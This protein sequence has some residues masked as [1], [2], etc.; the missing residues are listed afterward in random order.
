MKIANIIR[1][2][3]IISQ[4]GTVWKIR[5]KYCWV[6]FRNSYKLTSQLLFKKNW[7]HN[8]INYM[9]TYITRLERK[10][11]KKWDFVDIERENKKTLIYWSIMNHVS[12]CIKNQELLCEWSSW[13]VYRSI[14]NNVSIC[15]SKIQ[16]CLMDGVHDS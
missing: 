14:K 15:I 7:H 16:N 8:F 12:T 6:A 9:I 3:H 4:F 2:F 5:V 11:P 10:K 13:L 1:D